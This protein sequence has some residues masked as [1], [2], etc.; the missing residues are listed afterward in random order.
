MSE[1]FEDFVPELSLADPQLARLGRSRMA[2]AARCGLIGV[3]GRAVLRKSWSDRVELSQ[4]E[5]A[6]L[7]SAADPEAR[8]DVLGSRAHR[9]LADGSRDATPKRCGDCWQELGRARCAACEGDGKLRAGETVRDCPACGGSGHIVCPKCEGS[10][11]CVPVTIAYA[12]DRTISFAHLFAPE[13]PRTLSVKLVQFVA[14]RRSIPE[15]LG[16]DLLDEQHRVDAYR[17]RRGAEEYRG[18]RLGSALSRARHYIERVRRAPSV[19][20]SRHSASVWPLA[21]L[22]LTGG[23]IAALLLDEGRNPHV[24]LG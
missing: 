18:H 10:G 5:L 16:F 15:V 3:A 2:E 4:R 12:E 20:A 11:R 6:E 14:S 24:V 23:G 9:M 17:G 21:L 19:I 8:L 13:I 1:R 7:C 22:E